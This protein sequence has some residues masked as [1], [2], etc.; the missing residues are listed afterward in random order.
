MWHRLLVLSLIQASLFSHALARRIKNTKQV[1][2]DTLNVDEAEAGC[3]P[4]NPAEDSAEANHP[5]A[6]GWLLVICDHA[7]GLKNT[8]WTSDADPFCQIE[9]QDRRSGRMLSKAVGL[10]REDKVSGN[11]KKDGNIRLGEEV[12]FDIDKDPRTL[13]KLK[14]KLSVRDDDSIAG[15]GVGTY[16]GGELM[17]SKTV[18]L[19]PRGKKAVKYFN[20]YMDMYNGEI[21][22]WEWCPH[23]LCPQFPKPGRY[24][25]KPSRNASALESFPGAWEMQGTTRFDDGSQGTLSYRIRWCPY[26]NFDKQET[27]RWRQVRGKGCVKE[28][29]VF[30]DRRWVWSYAPDCVIQGMRL[31]GKDAYCYGSSYKAECKGHTPSVKPHATLDAILVKG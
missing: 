14:L 3:P 22:T 1:T 7:N 31:F 4:T 24:E 10:V 18:L 23:H 27:K 30:R 26:S 12:A 28:A 8:N 16:N 9:L 2:Q 20:Q 25:W 6:N 13:D 29:T 19:P 17:G 21:G 11:A 15:N 5:G